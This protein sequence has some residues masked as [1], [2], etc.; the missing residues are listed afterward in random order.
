MCILNR[1]HISTTTVTK[2]L[3]MKSL[4]SAV[5]TCMMLCAW[6]GA[7]AYPITIS[8]G[9]PLTINFDFTGH[10]DSVNPRIDPLRTIGVNWELLA[11]PGGR[12][13][14][15]VFTELGGLGP[16]LTSGSWHESGG[17]SGFGRRDREFIDGLFSLTFTPERGSA[18]LN[19]A[20][21][22][23]ITARR[24]V[25]AEIA[26]TLDQQQVSVPVPGTLALIGL[27][28]AALAGTQRKQL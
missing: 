11:T 20:N 10:L 27:G 3:I 21:A 22:R 23:A 1:N 17:F 14:I 16:L 8:E 7:Q 2:G 9:A 5:I 24:Q 13:T 12:G 19:S 6:S 25:I 15:E 28:L 26:G 4:F 18:I